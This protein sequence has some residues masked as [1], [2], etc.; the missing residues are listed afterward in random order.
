MISPEDCIVFLSLSI[1]P[2]E[3]VL[4]P[5]VG[6]HTGGFSPPVPLLWRSTAAMLDLSLISVVQIQIQDGWSGRL[7]FMGV[8]VKAV[9]LW[10]EAVEGTRGTSPSNQ[11]APC[12]V[13][14]SLQEGTKRWPKLCDGLVGLKRKW[15]TQEFHL[16]SVECVW[17][18]EASCDLISL[19]TGKEI[20]PAGSDSRLFCNNNQ[21]PFCT[22][23]SNSNW[24]SRCCCQTAK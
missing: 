3:G 14:R 18:H 5:S 6:F 20:K 15:K 23:A 1:H 10:A 16:V 24:L 9:V 13:K 12:I 17:L 7:E 22:V 8:M 2:Y 11:P 19:P 4:K 21:P